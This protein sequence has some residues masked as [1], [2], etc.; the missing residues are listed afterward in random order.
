MYK[1]LCFCFFISFSAIAAFDVSKYDILPGKFHKGGT[2]IASVKST[3]PA[4]KTMTIK[5]RF[6]V[7]KRTMV[8]VPSE[9]LKGELDQDFPIEF[10]DERGY[11]DLEADKT[12]DVSEAKATYIGRVDLGE[13]KN[14]HHVRV[15]AKNGRS[16]TDL[17]Y[18]PH[19]PGLGWAKVHMVIHPPL[20]ILKNYIVDAVLKD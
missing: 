11:L 7:E 3:N 20:P 2:F 12:L 17:Y 10:L 8:P 19:V 15:I 16:E 18:H 5:L 1:L 14:A 13:Y 6:D 4:K 9:Y